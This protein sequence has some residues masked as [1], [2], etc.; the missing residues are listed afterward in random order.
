MPPEMNPEIG[1][2]P[3]GAPA[4]A[5]TEMSAD[6][7]Q[8]ISSA[9]HLELLQ[10]FDKVKQASGNLNS[11]QFV[12]KNRSEQSKRDALKKVFDEMA[13]SGVDLNNPESVSA[14]MQKLQ[15]KNPDLYQ[16]FEEVMEQLLTDHPKLTPFAKALAATAMEK[17][18]RQTEQPLPDT[19]KALGDLKTSFLNQLHQ[20]FLPSDPPTAPTPL[21]PA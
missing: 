1:Q 13:A 5:P 12:A 11:M 21:T 9:Q 14:F 6:G 17:A 3:T 4:G 7:Q 15:D 20:W 16:L 10:L 8:P 2:M 19:A 18:A